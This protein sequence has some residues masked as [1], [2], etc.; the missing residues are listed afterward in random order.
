[1]NKVIMIGNLAND[2]EA[3]TT[4]SGISRS[5]FRLAVQR[6]YA[7]A[8]GVR[9]ADFFIIVAWRNTADFC[10][11][12][13]R[14]GRKIGLEGSIQTR[15]YETDDG[16]KRWVTEIIADSVEGL[17]SSKSGDPGPEEPAPRPG[18]SG[19]FEEVDDDEVPF[20]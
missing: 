10:N 20:R 8:E 3:Y 9:E 19:D 16:Q 12:Y 7:N 17:G 5:T 14:K 2:P 18:E 4:Q 1:M 13:L 6:R 15:S 11:K